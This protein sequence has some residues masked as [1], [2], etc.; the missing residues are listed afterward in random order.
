M[1]LQA[2]GVHD[3]PR[4]ESKSETEARRSSVKRRVS[5]PPFTP[6]RRLIET[7]VD[8]NIKQQLFV[9]EVMC[10]LFTVCLLFVYFLRL[11]AQPSSLASNQQ[12][13]SLSSNQI[14]RSITQHSRAQ[15]L[16]TTPIIHW[17]RLRPHCRNQPILGFTWAG[18]ATS[19]KVT[20]PRL[21]IL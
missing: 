4:P 17:E 9:D 10:C 1:V 19:S 8:N 20:W 3:H 21:H 14:S 12:T 7:Q 2:K 13:E 6:K 16:T 11:W 18:Q 5:S 15:S